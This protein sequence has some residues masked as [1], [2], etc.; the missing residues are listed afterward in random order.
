MK[1]IP[2]GE[3]STEKTFLAWLRQILAGQLAHL[4]RRFCGTQARDVNLE[5]AFAQ[6]LEHSSHLLDNSL[7]D[8]RT[9]PGEAVARRER[10]VLLAD[11]LGR[12]PADYREAIVLRQLEGLSFQNAAERMGRS[13]DSVQK[14]WVRALD[15][16]RQEMADYA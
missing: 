4:V 16:L 14:L 5:H 9:P 12:L 10:A 3:G 6:E 1:E 11:A 8:Q 2:G 15:R 13:V 7:V